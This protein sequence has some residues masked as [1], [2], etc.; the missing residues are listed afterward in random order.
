MT[1][2]SLT[3]LTQTKIKFDGVCCG[4]VQGEELTSSEEMEKA[5]KDRKSELT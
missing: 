5:I 1:K 2:N 3:D 4:Q